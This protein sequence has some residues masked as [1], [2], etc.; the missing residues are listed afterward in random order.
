MSNDADAYRW[1][2]NHGAGRFGVERASDDLLHRDDNPPG[3]TATETYY[4]GFHVIEE[5]IQGFIYLWFH[6]NLGVVTAGVMLS[7]GV[8]AC[9]LAAEYFN[10]HAYLRIEEH[11]DATTGAMRFPGGLV[12]TPVDLLRSWRIRLDDPGANTAFDLEFVAAMPAAVR[13]DQKHFDQNMHVRGEL[14]LRG[15][16]HSVDC[17]A[18]RDRSWQNERREDPMPVPPYD[19]VCLTRG[20]SFALNLSLFDDLRLLGDAGGALRLPPKLLQDGWVYGQGDL[21]RIVEVDKLTERSADILRPLR[22]EIRA[23]DEAGAIY[24]IRGESVGGCN[25]NGWPNMLWQQNL[26]RWTCNGE[27]AWGEVQEVQWHDFVRLHRRA[28]GS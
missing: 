27:T 5:A 2:T 12:L 3:A 4:F 15:R 23:V 22:H 24:D 8:Q 20:A 26:T 11:V 28:N 25:W 9:T 7:R 6:P 17:F 16:R 14:T 18:I 13:A 21:R 19:W 1:M 10:I